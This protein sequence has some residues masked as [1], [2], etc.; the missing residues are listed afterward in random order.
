VEGIKQLLATSMQDGK[1][2]VVIKDIVNDQRFAKSPLV[3]EKGIHFCAGEPLVNRNGSIVG[4]LLVLDTRTRGMSEQEKESL[5]MAAETAIEALE[6]RAVAPT[7]ETIG[8]NSPP[9]S[10]GD[11]RT[12]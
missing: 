11:V 1:S 8:T 6:L 3:Q 12:T 2:T 10:A 7:I 4:I 5:H 9:H